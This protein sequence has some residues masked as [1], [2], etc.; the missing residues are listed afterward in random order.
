MGDHPTR[1]RAATQRNIEKHLI[2]HDILE[3]HDPDKIPAKEIDP[4]ADKIILLGQWEAWL[5]HLT[6]SQWRIRMNGMG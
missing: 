5:P 4:T 6:F 3:G 2:R 1:I